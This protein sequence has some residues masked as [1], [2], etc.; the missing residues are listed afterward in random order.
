MFIDSSKIIQQYLKSKYN[1]RKNKANIEEKNQILLVKISYKIKLYILETT[2][3]F[4]YQ[5]N[6]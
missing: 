4:S 1:F 2:P 6:Q 5:K 3:A